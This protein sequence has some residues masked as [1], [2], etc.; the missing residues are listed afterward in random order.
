[1]INLVGD[2]TYGLV[3]LAY[4]VSIPGELKHP[5]SDNELYPGGQREGGDQ[6]YEEE[7]PQLGG[8]HGPQRGQVTEEGIRIE[9]KH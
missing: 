7:I 3:Y 2:G 8:G 1:M 9:L 4:N 6:N 5:Q